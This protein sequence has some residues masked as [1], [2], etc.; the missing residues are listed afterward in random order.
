MPRHFL[1]T[2]REVSF[3]VLPVEQLLAEMKQ[4]TESVI[5]KSGNDIT[6]W[7]PE[8]HKRSYFLRITASVSAYSVAIR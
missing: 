2:A 1:S 3:P 4:R 5:S 7:I 6:Y 8:A